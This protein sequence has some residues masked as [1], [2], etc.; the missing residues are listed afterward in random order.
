LYAKEL[1]DKGLEEQARQK[2]IEAIDI[3]PQMAYTFIKELKRRQ[4][5]FFVAPYEA[6]AQLAYLEKIKYVDMVITEDSDLLALGCEKVLFKLDLDTGF[7]IEIDLKNLSKCS[8]YNFTLFSHDKFLYFCILSGCDYFKLRGI[9]QKTAYQYVKDTKT[10]T[11]V[12]SN[13]RRGNK[14]IPDGFQENFEKAFLTFKFQV[15]F[16]PIQ[17]KMKH[18]SDVDGSEYKLIEKYGDLSFLGQ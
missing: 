3:N 14:F 17:G 10:Y 18:F 2:M 8:D 5:E 4:I 9:G 6:D 12:L 1:Y 13:V 16:C 11:E 15:I 7:G